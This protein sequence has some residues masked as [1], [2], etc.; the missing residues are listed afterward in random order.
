MAVGLCTSDGGGVGGA[1]PQAP[2]LVFLTLATAV[3]VRVVFL[4]PKG[5]VVTHRF[6]PRDHR[7]GP[8]AG[9][10]VVRG[11][12]TRRPRGKADDGVGGVG[13][14]AGILGRHTEA[15]QKL[16]A[17][18]ARPKQPRKDKVM[19]HGLITKLLTM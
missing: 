15:A 7:S 8:Q 12:S 6:G 4:T 18:I 11:K 9:K 3:H 10:P 1:R 2:T 17:R 13:M 5:P 14:E 16:V 19:D